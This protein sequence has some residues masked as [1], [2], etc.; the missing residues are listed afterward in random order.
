M[1]QWPFKTHQFYSFLVT[2]GKTSDKTNNKGAYLKS[3]LG[4]QF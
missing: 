1:L 2:A 3:G 4:G